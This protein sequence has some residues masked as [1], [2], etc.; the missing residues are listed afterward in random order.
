MMHNGERVVMGVED[1]AG[2][3]SEEMEVGDVGGEEDAA[4]PFENAPLVTKQGRREFEE[5]MQQQG[6]DAKSEVWHR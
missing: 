5:V 3:E 4:D 2:L 1:D 6:W